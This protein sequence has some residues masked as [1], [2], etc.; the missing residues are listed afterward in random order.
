MYQF[1]YGV[2]DIQ[3]KVIS[4]SNASAITVSCPNSLSAGF[5]VLCTQGG[6]GQV[7]FTSVAGAFLRQRQSAYKTA[8]QYAVVSLIVM[9][10]S[11]GTSAQW[12]MGGD[13][14]T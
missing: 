2:S 3:G 7:T 12:F 9:T 4:F 14:A 11:T 8:G 5:T 6:A 13:T 10:N 1:V